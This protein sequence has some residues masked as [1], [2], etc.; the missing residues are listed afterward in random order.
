[1]LNVVLIQLFVVGGNL[2][3]K[4]LTLQLIGDEGTLLRVC[5]HGKAHRH[6]SELIEERVVY[7]K[8]PR[9]RRR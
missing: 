1:M 5:L 7:M 8:R 6:I 9:Q 4:N 2:S 3:K